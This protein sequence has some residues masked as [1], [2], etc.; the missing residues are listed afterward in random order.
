[1]VSCIRDRG[2]ANGRVVASVAVCLWLEGD[3][4]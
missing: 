2:C 3:E 4:V 1:M